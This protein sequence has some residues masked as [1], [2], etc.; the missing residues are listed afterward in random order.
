MSKKTQISTNSKTSVKEL[1][2]LKEETRRMVDKSTY[3]KSMLAIKNDKSI[4][5]IQRWINE[6]NPFLTTAENQFWIKKGLALDD[7]YIIIDM[8]KKDIENAM[9][10]HSNAELRTAEILLS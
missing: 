4:Y 2:K 6:N 7:G 10:T 3:L 5:T 9:A 8:P 1:F